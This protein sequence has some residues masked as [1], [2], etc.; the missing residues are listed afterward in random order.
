MVKISY[1]IEITVRTIARQNEAVKSLTA[2]KILKYLILFFD[3]RNFCP[4]KFLQ[5]KYFKEFLAS[6]NFLRKILK[7]AK[8]KKN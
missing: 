4:T 5:F 3:P 6:E 8:S 2:T 7:A 1:P